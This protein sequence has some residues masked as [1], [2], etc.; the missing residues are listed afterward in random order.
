MST[1]AD[2]SG[3]AGH[4]VSGQSNEPLTRPAHALQSAQVLLE[5]GSNSTTGLSA[6]AAAER[7]AKYGANDLGKQKGVQPLQI[8]IAQI[9]NC[10]TMVSI[11]KHR[12]QPVF[13]LSLPLNTETKYL[14][15]FSG[16]TSGPG[17]QFRHSV[18]DCRWCPGRTDC[19]QRCHWLLPGSPCPADYCLSGLAQLR[20]R[21]CY[22]RR[23]CCYRRRYFSR[24][25]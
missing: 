19:H 6:E 24:P 23:C 9:V 15:F 14:R 10:M 3:N 17:C 8:F 13:F 1:K 5:L 21:S 4:H 18:M 16:P 2:A 11:E 12:I 22:P 25:R 7:L 20:H